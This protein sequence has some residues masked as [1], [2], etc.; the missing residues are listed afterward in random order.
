MSEASSLETQSRPARGGVGG[1]LTTLTSNVTVVVASLVFACVAIVVGWVPPRGRWA[2]PVARGWGRCLLFSAGVRLR[3]RYEAELD[4]D[5][6]YIF[7]SN[8]QSLFDIPAVAL[9]LP[10]N[11]RFLAKRSL[12]RIPVFGWSLAVAG[13]VPVDRGRSDK[14]AKAFS[15]SI[16]ALRQGASLVIFPEETR[17]LDG[18][19]GPFKR[20]GF[21]MA[22]KEGVAI[23][24]VGVKG[25]FE[26]RRKGSMWTR[27]GVVEVAVGS[28][29]DV[30]E[31]GLK[32]K[33]ELIAKVAAEVKRLAGA[34]GPG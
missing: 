31:Y 5:C 19:L 12:F 34:E 18:R 29:I 26:V 30:S 28:P 21:L 32:R 9:S 6:G 25:S 16:E 13:F 22:L 3:R 27:A 1:L 15:S 14:G 2:V 33:N 4:P 8:H 7:M 11:F 20:G 17:S 23:V 10:V 24:P